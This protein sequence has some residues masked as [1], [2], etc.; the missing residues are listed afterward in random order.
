MPRTGAVNRLSCVIPPSA[1][2][3]CP[4]AAPRLPSCTTCKR[5]HLAL[6]PLCSGIT[7]REGLQ[8]VST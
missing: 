7:L 3:A 1:A 4:R 8:H 6:S 2:L 5:G